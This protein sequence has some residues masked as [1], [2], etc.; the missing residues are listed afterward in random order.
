MKYNENEGFKIRIK[1]LC[2]SFDLGSK[3]SGKKHKKSNG[4]NKG[5]STGFVSNIVKERGFIGS[6]RFFYKILILSGKIM[7][8]AIEGIRLNKMKISIDVGASDAA[9]VAIEYGQ[10]SALLY[11]S[12]AFITSL[13]KPKEYKVNV[14]PNFL[15]EKISMDTELDISARAFYIVF[16]FLM[17]AKKYSELM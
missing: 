14:S 5:K 3:S 7:K 8:K 1:S 2:F 10:V 6:L 13:T 16:I 17:F 11:P 4:R 9:A 12:V 15:S